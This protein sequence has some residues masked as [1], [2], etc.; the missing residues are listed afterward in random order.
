MGWQWWRRNLGA[1]WCAQ[2]TE[3][4]T[5]EPVCELLSMPCQA[6]NVLFEI[7]ESLCAGCWNFPAAVLAS[8]ALNFESQC[9]IMLWFVCVRFGFMA[10][11]SGWGHTADWKLI[12]Q[13]KP[14]HNWI[15]EV[16]VK[17]NDRLFLL[18]VL[19]PPAPNLGF[20]REHEV[21]GRHRKKL[22]DV[23]AVVKAV[24]CL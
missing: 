6:F 17:K 5:G 2:H 12:N 9:P 18:K 22:I 7:P 23:I 20:Q 14:N 19:R 15:L 3:D 1:Q 13:T 24:W 11:P 21:F 4:T 16:V 10:G 8:P